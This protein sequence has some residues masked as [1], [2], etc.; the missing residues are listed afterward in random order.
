MKRTC[1]C[2]IIKR[3]GTKQDENVVQRGTLVA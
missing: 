3:G 2:N 1:R